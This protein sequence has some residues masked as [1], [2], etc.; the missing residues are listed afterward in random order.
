MNYAARRRPRRAAVSRLLAAVVALC[1]VTFGAG[2]QAPGELTAGAPTAGELAASE[3]L[4]AVKSDSTRLLAFLRAMPKGGDLH[5]HL[6]GATRPESWARWAASDG[7]CVVVATMTLVRPPCGRPGLGPATKLAED[8]VLLA[9]AVDAWSM[10]DW[11]PASE[12]GA[13]HFFATFDKTSAVGN[14]HLG[15]M[16]AEVAAR[17]A[18]EHVSYLE[19]MVNADDGGVPRLANRVAW[20]SDLAALRG[21]LEHAGLRDALHDASSNLDRAERRER[22]LLRC[23]TAAAD[24]GCAVTVRYIY[25]VIRSRS[26]Q[27]VFAQILAGFELPAVDHRYVSFNLVAP[28]HGAV[29]VRDFDLHMHMI[30]FLRSSFPAVPITLHAGELSDQV[31]ARDVMRSHVRESVEIAH[32]SRIG[33]GVDVLQ[34]DGADSL[35]REMAARHVLVEV[36]L[37]S[38]DDILGVRGTAHPLHAFLSHGVPVALVS[39]DEGVAQ[40][41]MTHEY[42]RAVVDQELDYRTLKSLARNSLAY[43][44]AADST[45][46]RLESEL[47]GAFARFES[48]LTTTA[49]PPHSTSRSTNRQR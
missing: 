10:H 27:H 7:L 21:Q 36:A 15:E 30:A 31:A 20:T 37:T 43:S 40:S 28:E 16:L 45:K 26:P 35:L 2:A 38:N 13:D 25:Q 49:R 8:S 3:R 42:S 44:F 19:L 29:A 22:E 1:A 32:A 48:E 11:H 9:R 5:N 34:E 41:D 18:A 12:S 14:A 33:H 24:A 17:A 47:D 4:A 23:G 39:D 46:A 6:S